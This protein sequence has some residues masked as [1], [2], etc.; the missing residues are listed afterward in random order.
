MA[1]K[2]KKQ[3]RRMTGEAVIF[4]QDGRVLLVQQGTT[5]HRRWELPGG[6]V[7]K[8]ESLPDAVVR[9]VKEE[10]GLDVTPERL[11]GIFYVRSQNIYDFVVQCRVN[12]EEMKPKANPPEI[13]A[14]KFFSIDRLPKPIRGFTVD[15]IADAREGTIYPLPVELSKEEWV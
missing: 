5:R 14:C 15:R 13:I 4:N 3:K 2:K 8:R 9:E 1:K 10:T 7:K 11:L 6:K 12:D